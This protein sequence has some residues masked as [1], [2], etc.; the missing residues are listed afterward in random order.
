VIRT[1]AVEV[2]RFGEVDAE[3]AWCEVEGDR[4]LEYWRAAHISFFEAGGRQVGDQSEVVLER[5]DLLWG[6][7]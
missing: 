1:T 4:S 6:G 5:F 7:A 2:L 3:F